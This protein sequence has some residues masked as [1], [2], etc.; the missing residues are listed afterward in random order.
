MT[1][2]NE[3]AIQLG[4]I[5]IANIV[6]GNIGEVLY[7]YAVYRM[8]L[9]RDHK[10][11]ISSHHATKYEQAELEIKYKKFEAKD[12][13]DDYAELVVQVG[14]FWGF[15]AMMTIWFSYW[16]AVRFRHSFCCCVPSSSNFCSSE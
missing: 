15:V 12:A 14:C 16:R 11:D 6:V 4:T 9:S 8:N 10:F 7:P 13:F 1:C 3:L 2:I 5:F